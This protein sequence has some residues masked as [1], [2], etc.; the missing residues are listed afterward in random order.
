MN[1][2]KNLHTYMYVGCI[3]INKYL[4]LTLP[5]FEVFNKSLKQTQ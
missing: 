3:V 4:R 5:Q 2:T 1:T